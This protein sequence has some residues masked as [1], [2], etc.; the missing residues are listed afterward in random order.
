[1][2]LGSKR[3]LRSELPGAA[4]TGVRRVRGGVPLRRSNR[5][6]SPRRRGRGRRRRHRG[7]GAAL[8]LGAAFAGTS[9]GKRFG[10][11]GPEALEWGYA[12]GDDSPGE[13]RDTEFAFELHHR[14][15]LLLFGEVLRWKTAR[16]AELAG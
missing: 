13:G 12:S 7:L 8:R 14:V 4:R 1:M 9:D 2:T 6:R 3:T 10:R 15:G 5:D 11:W 16:A